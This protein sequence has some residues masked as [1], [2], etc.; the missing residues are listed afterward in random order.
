M[1][2]V[3]N[4]ITPEIKDFC[5]EISPKY[6]PCFRLILPFNFCHPNDCGRNVL[7]CVEKSGGY[8]IKGWRL[9]W[10][11]DILIEAPAHVI[12]EDNMKRTIDVTPVRDNEKYT[13]FLQDDNLT[14]NPGIDFIYSRFKNLEGS[15]RIDRY[16]K[17]VKIIAKYNDDIKNG[18]VLKK[19]QKKELESLLKETDK[20]IL[21]LSGQVKN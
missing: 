14:K 1:L 18:K 15:G 6:N 20:I 19:K 10:I 12:W 2:I 9:W 13:L 21:K 8:T 11:P 5:K 3:P 17:C 16:I 7:R 4:E